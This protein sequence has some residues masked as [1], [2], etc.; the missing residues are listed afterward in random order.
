MH[1]KKVVLL[2]EAKPRYLDMVRHFKATCK[3]RNLI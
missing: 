3:H 2:I 1:R